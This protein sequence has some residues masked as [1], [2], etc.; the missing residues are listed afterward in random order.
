MR[1]ISI[2]G[3]TF[4]PIHN[5]HIRLALSCQD[6]LHFDKILIIPTNLPPHKETP[7]LCSNK[8]R[9]EMCR[10]AVKDMPI[11]EVSDVEYRLGGRSYTVN[12]LQA[13]RTEYP[14]ASFYLLVGSDMFF[15]FRQWKRYRDILN[16]C[17]LV[18]ASRDFEEHRNLLE[19]NDS[20]QREGFH[21]VV[22]D[23]D[24]Y[25]L[26]STELRRLMQ[27]HK[28]ISQYVHP[29]VLRY[30]KEHSL[31]GGGLNYDETKR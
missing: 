2:L 21:T 10:L 17:T 30:I 6:E 18:G 22:I 9:F 7:N 16:A 27:E 19:M 25:V 4:N 28:D 23:N 24:V 12:T 20:F 3:G 11:F 5:G 1:K 14:D 26:S 29:D 13:L 15:T 31:F 8:D